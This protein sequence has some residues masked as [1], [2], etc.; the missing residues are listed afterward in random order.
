MPR[1]D[2]VSRPIDAVTAMWCLGIVYDLESALD[3]AVDLLRP[4]GSLSIIDF[5]KSRPNHGL[6]RWLFPLYSIALRTAGI[7]TAE[8]LDNARLEV[9]WAHGKELL[10]ARLGTLTEEH[11]LSGVGLIVAA[12]KPDGRC[13]KR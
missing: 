6:L 3:R 12:R 11:F 2:S 10:K 13:D 1:L 5:R 9:K 7:D 4:G 8:D